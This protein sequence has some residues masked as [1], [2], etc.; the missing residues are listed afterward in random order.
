MSERRK[1]LPFRGARTAA[2]RESGVGRAGSERSGPEGSAVPEDA[3]PATPPLPA[4]RAGGPA[5][6]ADHLVLN[7]IGCFDWDL[8]A[9][10]VHLDPVALRL[11]GLGAR[12]GS[13][14]ADP[15]ALLARAV[16]GEAAATIRSIVRVLRDGRGEWARELRVPR[17]DGRAG[18]VRAQGRVVR[19]GT[20]RP[21]RMIG[22]VTEVTGHPDAAPGERPPGEDERRSDEHGLVVEVTASLAQAMTV[23]DVTA[24]LTGNRRLDR[25]GIA[26]VFL[27]LVEPG[28]R[29]R[30]TAGTDSGHPA[31]GDAPELEWTRVDEDF[32]MS[33]VVRTRRPR[34]ITSREEFARDYPRLWPYIARLDASA[35][36]YL[37]LVAQGRPVGALGLFYRRGTTFPSGERNL[38]LALGGSIEQSLQRARLFDQ[39]HDLAEGLQTAMLPRGIPRIPGAEIAVRYR[40]A[41]LA[42][43]I[44]GDWYDV[45]AVPGG[46]VAAIIGDVQ[47]HDTQAAA[48][49]GQLRIA[50][51]AYAAEGHPPATVVGRGSAFLGELDTDRFATCLYAEV[52]PATGDAVLVRAG[53]IDPLLRMAGGGSRRL[54]VTGGL[55]LGLS[56]EFGP[57]DYPVTRAALDPG[58]T[59]LMFT[60]GLVERPG[61]DLDDGLRELAAVLDGGPP[62]AERLADELCAGRDGGGPGSPA[63]EDDM[64]LLVLRRDPGTAARPARRLHQHVG[65]GDPEALANA[66]GMIRNAATAWQIA[67][68]A[69]EAELAA[70]ELLTN[71]LV[72]TGGGAVLTLR[73]TPDPRPR[74]RIEVH[75]LATNWPRRRQPG[76]RETSGRGLVLVDRLADAWGV[77][78]Y[79]SG[80]SVWCEFDAAAGT[81]VAGARA[82]AAA[83]PPAAARGSRRLGSPPGRALPAGRRA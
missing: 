59:L 37:P 80:K 71:A 7:G 49:M 77:D 78:P 82:T 38:L 69:D 35:A 9:R 44:G 30:L 3:V 1:L 23:S 63:A 54:A 72:H 64:A 31:M 48:V 29:L 6:A 61:A 66:R 36:A 20:G 8:D 28:G 60:D 21:C 40:S 24:A 12:D 39:E 41:R 70:D 46:R 74:L 5:S 57:P 32:P 22:V 33:E 13:A 43:D 73:M 56:T 76:D 19:D 62:D 17:R 11:L 67:D 52:D 47:G 4:H 53:H 14:D 26:S 2:G 42:R 45:V 34:F 16:P 75:D 81:A 83:G 25:L 68:R 55:P 50:L 58:D 65:P 79:G 18:R 51:R 27:G 10:R 15:A